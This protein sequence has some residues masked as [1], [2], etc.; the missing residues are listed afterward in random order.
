[1]KIV[2]QGYITK[3]I[4]YIFY[5]SSDLN[6]NYKLYIS[7]NDG[8]NERQYTFKFASP[9]SGADDQDNRK[10]DGGA[11]RSDEEQSDEGKNGSN[12]NGENNDGNSTKTFL[13]YFFSILIPLMVIIILIY[14]FI[15][16]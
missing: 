3:N 8:N 11:D 14:C 1:M 13:I 12:Q 2:K 6:E 16:I 9:T 5:T 4:D 15:I 10:D 7:D